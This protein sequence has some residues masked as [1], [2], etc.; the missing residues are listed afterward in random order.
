M[1][2]ENSV[3]AQFSDVGTWYPYV[4]RKIGKIPYNEFR[5]LDYIDISAQ[6]ALSSSLSKKPRSSRTFLTRQAQAR[7]GS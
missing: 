3:V 5:T 6:L 2:D 1:V 4:K 7:E